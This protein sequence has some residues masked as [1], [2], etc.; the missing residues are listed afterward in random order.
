MDKRGNEKDTALTGGYTPENEHM[1][2]HVLLK[3]SRSEF[4]KEFGTIVLDNYSL[5]YNGKKIPVIEPLVLFG[6]VGKIPI[7]V[8]YKKSYKWLGFHFDQTLSFNIHI[9]TLKKKAANAV[10]GLRMLANTVRGLHQYHLKLLYLACILPI[11]TYGV[12]VWW[13]GKKGH[14]QA[15]EGVQNNALRVMMPVFKTT[16][17]H[18][19]QVEAGLPPIRFRLDYL[20]RYA[21][22]RMATKTNNKNPLHAR[23]PEPY[24]AIPTHPS[25]PEPALPTIP[26]LPRRRKTVPKGGWRTVIDTVMK[27]TPANI[28]KI[29]C[30]AD[31]PPW[32]FGSDDE[33]IGGRLRVTPAKLGVTKDEAAKSHNTLVTEKKSQGNYI[34]GYTDGSQRPTATGPI[35]GAGWVLYDEANELGS[36]KEGLGARA[37]VY[38]AEMVALLRGLRLAIEYANTEPAKYLNIILFSDNDSAVK[39]ITKEQAGANQSISIDFM[40]AAEVFLKE[41]EGRTLEVAWVPGHKD[42]K[43]NDEADRLAK[44]AT[45]LPIEDDTPTTF[46]HHRRKVRADLTANWNDY[47]LSKPRPESKFAVADRIA[48]S[49]KGSK[50][51]KK[52]ERKEYG[53][54]TQ[55]RTGH[56]YYGDYYRGIGKPEMAGCPCGEEIQTRQHIL[57]ECEDYEASRTILLG[58]SPTLNMEEILGSERGIKAL[59]KFLKRSGAFQ[60]RSTPVNGVG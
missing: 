23:L 14:E 40:R 60:K 22:T 15:L 19:L 37:E 54:V 44:E 46:T 20:R 27:T 21:G 33:D 51:F 17:I 56:G 12:A 3:R 59:A 18:A 26:T 2:H 45:E 16:Q 28:E 5:F 25:V 55:V 43:G 9:A 49:L 36:G 32:R 7:T 31:L 1:I 34:L 13:S 6:G 4:E 57:A 39:N 35:N 42:V 50:S 29:R 48:P 41:K 47:W 52:M 24:K 38:D 58:H 53:L 30:Y 8:P 11:V 10:G